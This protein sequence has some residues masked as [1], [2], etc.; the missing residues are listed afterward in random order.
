MPRRIAAA[1]AL[2]LTLA[3]TP[4]HAAP[5]TNHNVFVFDDMFVRGAAIYGTLAVGRD[6][7]LEQTYIFD[8]GLRGV[9]GR[10]P[11]ALLV[12]GNLR[13]DEGRADGDIFVAGSH[14][15]HDVASL[16]PS[17]IIEGPLPVDLAAEA[18]R[19][20]DL[21]ALI[22]AQPVNGTMT[23]GSMLTL[24]ATNAGINVFSLNQAV[25]DLA[26]SF[27]IEAP[28]N[29]TVLVNM[30]GNA[31]RLFILPMALSGGIQE[32]SVLYNYHG[33]DV[34]LM[35]DSRVLG[36]VL[37]PHANVT[38]FG[39]GVR[40]DFVARRMDGDSFE[41]GL[42][43]FSGDLPSAIVVATPEPASLALLLPALAALAARRRPEA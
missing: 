9:D 20:T 28:A 23:T 27:R 42:A 12:G 39:G 40:G 26:T 43:P 25:L 34:F 4:A 11:P 35:A 30:E 41:I 18:A 10:L 37:A 3:T 19:L 31:D 38:F 32:T 17:S 14:D 5:L 7:I 24:T 15:I 6:S 8:S 1:L 29:A 33:A 2:A 16:P 36:S 22:A 21:S 13:F